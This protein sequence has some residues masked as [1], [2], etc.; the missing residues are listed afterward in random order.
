MNPGRSQPIRTDN[1]DS[2]RR[3]EGRAYLQGACRGNPFLENAVESL[4]ANCGRREPF[5]S[6]DRLRV[7]DRLLHYRL[8]ERIAEGSTGIVYKAEDLHVERFV[9]LK[10]LSPRLATDVNACRRFLRE[11]RCASAL[12]HPNVITIHDIAY[13]RGVYFIVMEYVPGTS[14]AGMIDRRAL[15]LQT[16]LAYSVQIAEGLMKAHSAGIVYRD[17]KPA[18]IVIT[19]NGIVKL[20]DFGLAKAVG[21][22]RK[23]GLHLD[24]TGEGA[25]VGTVAYMSPEQ[26]RS[27]R[28]DARSDIFSF[29]VML[30]EM[31]TGRRLFRRDTMADTI[32]SVLRD[33][34]LVFPKLLPPPVMQIVRGCLQ[35]DVRLR[36]QTM[37]HVTTRLRAVEASLRVRNSSRP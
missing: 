4:L 22:R 24:C 28:L 11:A 20:A 21:T 13:D 6:S 17:L 18:N 9:A 10:V 12:S 36:F 19:P 30:F 1:T 32:A 16:C 26:I 35:K 14:L 27:Q 7:G 31:L 8:T 15:S 3:R 23:T 33:D 37:G 5:L 2:A 29:G 34:P 25:I